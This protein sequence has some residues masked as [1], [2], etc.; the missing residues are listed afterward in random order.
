[1][2]L[3]IVGHPT[4]KNT[5]RQDTCNRDSFRFMNMHDFAMAAY[6][7]NYPYICWNDRVYAIDMDDHG[8]LRYRDTNLLK[9]DVL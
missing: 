6:N 1:M 9:E 5:L 8:S 2:S 3:G 4:W 7:I